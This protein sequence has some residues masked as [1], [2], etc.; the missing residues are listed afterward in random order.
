MT[1]NISVKASFKDPNHLL[2]CGLFSLFFCLVGF[3]T[4]TAP[5]VIVTWLPSRADVKEKLITQ[6]AVAPFWAQLDSV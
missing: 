6:N 4:A 2:G 5:A 1:V 3:V